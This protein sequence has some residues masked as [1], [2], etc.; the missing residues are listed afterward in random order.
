MVIIMK[1]KL[2][3]QYIKFFNKPSSQHGF[4]LVELLL[5]SVMSI[6][7]VGSAG[8]GLVAILGANSTTEAKTQR[9]VELNRALEFI[10]EDVK[11]S[12]KV[13]SSGGLKL[14]IPP[15]ATNITYSTASSSS[16]GSIWIKNYVV[17]KDS[18]VLVDALVVPSASDITQMTNACS[19]TDKAFVNTGQGFYA[20]I[21]DS[22]TATAGIQ[23][24]RVDLYLYGK[25]GSKS[26]DYVKVKTTAFA[27]A[28]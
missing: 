8:Y 7:V 26:T 25:T 20:C 1:P 27:R 14:T 10:S 11:M 9:Q 21:Y 5:A 2:L 15:S 16:V 17:K 23:G 18:D 6:F 13:E 28:Q 12:N 3:Y 4:T 19:G 22:D 24:R